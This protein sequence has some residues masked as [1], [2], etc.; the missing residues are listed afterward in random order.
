MQKREKAENLV[1]TPGNQML[2]GTLKA[3][4][5]VDQELATGRVASIRNVHGKI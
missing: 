3:Y 4:A 1:P 2:V 5:A